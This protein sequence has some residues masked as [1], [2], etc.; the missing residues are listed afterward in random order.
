MQQ[1]EL[2]S[3]GSAYYPVAATKNPT[4]VKSLILAA[5]NFMHDN[6]PGCAVCKR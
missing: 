3:A 1:A 2:Q 4:S 5:N 6:L